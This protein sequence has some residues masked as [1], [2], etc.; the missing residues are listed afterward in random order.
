MDCWDNWHD[1]QCYR[2]DL[3]IFNLYRLFWKMGPFWDCWRNL[4]S[5]CF[6]IFSFFFSLSYANVDACSHWF[7]FEFMRILHS[8]KIIWIWVVEK[9][10]MYENAHNF[11]YFWICKWKTELLKMKNFCWNLELLKSA[12]DIEGFSNLSSIYEIWNPY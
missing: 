2:L 6:T 12:V 3:G 10:K 9:A 5:A 8:I 11:T 4:D 7:H 1:A